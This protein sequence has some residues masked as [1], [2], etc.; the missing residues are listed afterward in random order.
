MFTVPFLN[1]CCIIH[2]IKE[3]GDGM[4]SHRVME[5][6]MTQEPKILKFV[7]KTD[8]S[9]IWYINTRYYMSYELHNEELAL[10]DKEGNVTTINSKDWVLKDM[11]NS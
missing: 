2:I 11:Q 6:N 1:K 7:H 9:R 3:K 5:K 4:I 10:T 8:G